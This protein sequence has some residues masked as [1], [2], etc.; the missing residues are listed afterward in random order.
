MVRWNSESME[1]SF[2]GVAKPSGEK[3]WSL[4]DK[5]SVA[6]NPGNLSEP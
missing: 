1:L 4:P 2:A 3:E 5:P 6:L